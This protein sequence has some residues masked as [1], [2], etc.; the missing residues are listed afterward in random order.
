ML[1]TMVLPCVMQF[2]GQD[3]LC[4]LFNL[5]F[6]VNFYFMFIIQS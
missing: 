1:L 3:S 4:D 2:E 6:Y 5:N